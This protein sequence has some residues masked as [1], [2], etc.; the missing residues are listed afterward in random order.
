MG[1]IVLCSDAFSLGYHGAVAHNDRAHWHFTTFASNFGQF[2]TQTHIQFM[3]R[4]IHL[5]HSKEPDVMGISEEA[6]HRRRGLYLLEIGKAGRCAS[7][8]PMLPNDA[9]HGYCLPAWPIQASIDGLPTIRSQFER[10]PLGRH[11]RVIVKA[12]QIYACAF[13]PI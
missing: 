11:Q 12:L 4:G 8:F 6:R 13:P 9:L 1:N 3:Q 2:Q 5:F 10:K 7:V